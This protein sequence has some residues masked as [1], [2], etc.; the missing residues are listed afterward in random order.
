MTIESSLLALAS[1]GPIPSELLLQN[2]RAQAFGTQ[3]YGTEEILQAFAE[4]PVPSAM[5]WIAGG[6]HALL[7]SDHHALF[8]DVAGDH[9]SRLW[10]LGADAPAAREP[11]IDVPFDP[12]LSQAPGAAAFR[13]ADHPGLSAGHRDRVA[14]LATELAAEWRS[15]GGSRPA[16]VRPYCLRAFSSGDQCCALFAVHVLE[17]GNMRRAGFVH[18]AA[19]ADSSGVQI[20]RAE[21]EEA[22]MGAHEWRPRAL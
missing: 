15:P 17:G 13:P 1:G 5:K 20:I 21:A 8:F 7:L 19:I 18:V 10:R 9:V 11:S 6:R 2:C 4:Q 14:G 3:L 16:R 22:A 12:D